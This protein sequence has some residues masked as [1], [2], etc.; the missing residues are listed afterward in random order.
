[1]NNRQQ[2]PKHLWTEL[3]KGDPIKVRELDDEH[4]EARFVMAEVERLYDEGTSPAEVAV[5]YRTNAQSRVL[6]DTLVRAGIS[7][8]VVG[9][10]KFYDR[11][12]IKDAIA[13]LITLVNPQDAG[14]FTRIVNSPRRGI[15]V[16]SV[17][18]LLSFANTTGASVW[19]AVS[20]P[21]QV[22]GLGPPAVKALK[23]FMGTMHVLRER[24]E[25]R[26]PVAELLK[27]VL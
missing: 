1:P 15:G 12:E 20:D 27:E 7:Y 23:R 6:E 4:A 16:T 13:Y 26:G 11:A 21:D 2:K 5:F 10:T 18:R 24:V 8:Q 17:S 22:P 14:A 3:G 9:G 25:S 19:E